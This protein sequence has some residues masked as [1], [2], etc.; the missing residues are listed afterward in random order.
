[1]KTQNYT[2]DKNGIQKMHQLI[3]VPKVVMLATQ[4]NKTPFSVCPMTLQELDDQGQMWFFS[5]KTSSHFSDIQE[6]NSVQIMYTDELKQQYISIY[7]NAT[8]IVDSQKTKELW[9]PK[10]NKWFEG[11][12]DSNLA[13]LCVN[14]EQASYW[15]SGLGK[16]VSFFSIADGVIQDNPQNV[17]S[18]GHIDM[19]NH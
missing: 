9:N 2:K 14:I 5:S 10:F 19:Q 4:L 17:G 3:T 8:H 1:M 13:L 11:M 15:D 12:D 6:D 7:G 16:L 18:K